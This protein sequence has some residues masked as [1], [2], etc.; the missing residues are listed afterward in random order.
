MKLMIEIGDFERRGKL[1]CYL[2]ACIATNKP[3]GDGVYDNPDQA[4]QVAR[5]TDLVKVLENT[6]NG[7]Y[8]EL[9]SSDK[10]SSKR[11]FVK[12]G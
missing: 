6:V 9:S 4:E 7:Y 2:K 3:N 11:S 1:K 5:F 12:I 8:R 10:S